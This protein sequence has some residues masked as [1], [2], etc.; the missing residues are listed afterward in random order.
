MSTEFSC[1]PGWLVCFAV[2]QGAL[3]GNGSSATGRFDRALLRNWMGAREPLCFPGR[4]GTAWESLT[5]SSESKVEKE[6]F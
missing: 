3:L 4:R 5:N 2:P 6:Q 1:S